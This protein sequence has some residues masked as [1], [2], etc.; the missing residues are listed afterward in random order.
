MS[1]ELFDELTGIS[2]A[3]ILT[4]LI[5]REVF[6]FLQ[7]RKMGSDHSIAEL[8]PYLSSIDKK[9]TALYDWHN[10]EDDD[11]V[12]VWYVRKSLEN[13]IDNLNETIQH[14]EKLFRAIFDK[15]EQ[16]DRDVKDLKK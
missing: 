7:R 16:I 14:Q 13:A 12:K 11:G 9:I 6:N 15:I 8:K 4:I 1:P 3:G 2:V 5:L 10:K